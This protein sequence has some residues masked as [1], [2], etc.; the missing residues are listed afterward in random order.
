MAAAQFALQVAAFGQW[1]L[2]AGIHD[3]AAG[4]DH[5]KV[6]EG[7]VGPENSVEHGGGEIG[8]DACSGFGNTAQANFAL[9]G[10]QCADFSAREE[11]GGFD[12][13]FD[14]FIELNRE[15]AEEAGFAK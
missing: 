9:D 15:A 5:A 3:S 4:D 7:R 8:I 2:H 14:V 10:D 11:H 6:M 12:E 13:G 1:E